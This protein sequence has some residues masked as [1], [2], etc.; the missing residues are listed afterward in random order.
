MEEL[1]QP[2]LD[3][4]RFLSAAEVIAIYEGFSRAEVRF[5]F[6]VERPSLKT[7]NYIFIKPVLGE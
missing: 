5:L 6:N 4:F 2:Y 3:T 1:I 7:K